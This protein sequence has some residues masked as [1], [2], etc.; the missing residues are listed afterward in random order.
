MSSAA[1]TSSTPRQRER[2]DAAAV[3]S[4]VATPSATRTR[5]STS[6]LLAAT[7]TS[8]SASASTLLRS[9]H[10]LYGNE[11]RIVLDLGSSV[12]KVGF[13]GEPS[14]RACLSVP[15]LL[16][17]LPGHSDERELWKLDKNEP[18]P[19]VWKV[20]E[21]RTRRCLRHVWQDI[22]M[23]DSKTRKVVIV[24]SA[25]QSIKVKEMITRILFDGMHVPSISH[26]PACVLSLM[27]CGTVTGLVLDCGNLET[28]IV[29][30]F[31]SRPMYSA[32][33]STP[34]ASQRLSRR[35]RSLLLLFGSYA[36][37]PSSLNSNARPTISRV[38]AEV[39]SE[40]L[41]E[42][43]L[44]RLC[45]VGHAV[46]GAV[47]LDSAPEPEGVQ[48]DEEDS[49]DEDV[50]LLRN[51]EKR[52]A[53]LS[54]AT[55]V[56]FPI[57]N[58]GRTAATGGVGRGWVQVPG[59]IRERAAEVLFESGDED[60]A[61]L[62]ELVLECLN[63]LPIDLRKTMA[64]NI[65]VTGGT[66]MLPGFI[67]RLSNALQTALAEAH[68]PSPPP[69][70]T[71]DVDRADSLSHARITRRLSAFR[72]RSRYAGLSPLK[73]F[74]AILNNPAHSIEGRGNAKSGSAPAF[75]PALL[76][77]I[78]GSLVGALK[79]GGVDLQRDAWDRLAEETEGA[80]AAIVP[81]WT[82]Q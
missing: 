4:S 1:G 61:S 64:S 29:P 57:P 18:G 46:R 54:M 9:R 70:P 74:V 48:V 33:L 27:A 43:M 35:L 62:V 8:S 19:L 11:D 26:A 7:G 22:L 67:P 15:A 6:S 38:P 37:P 31:A 20:R 69:S 52:F 25:L 79:G 72:A 28:T 66:A 82:R 49:L 34:R 58:Y 63:N 75:A 42:D 5:P 23:I 3:R 13:S 55:T 60:E 41:L 16:G 44:A 59:W 14:P 17:T 10:S 32:M 68:P 81:D 45:Y 53:A 50:S 76:P 21:N 39:L 51:H 77:W 71:P 80:A 36:K 56:S 47:E 12:W 40:D 2:A 30:V 78:G 73:T 65:V 24:E